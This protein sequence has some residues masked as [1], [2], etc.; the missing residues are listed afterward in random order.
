MLVIRRREGLFGVLES[1]FTVEI[2]YWK[3]VDRKKERN[4]GMWKET[5]FSMDIWK[6]YYFCQK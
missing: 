2:F 6:I 3:V 4:V 5:P 1:F